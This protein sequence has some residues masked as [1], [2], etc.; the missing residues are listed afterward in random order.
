MRVFMERLRTAAELIRPCMARLLRARP[1][2]GYRAR[3]TRAE[4]RDAGQRLYTAAQEAMGSLSPA[5]RLLV[6]PLVALLPGLGE[7]FPG[8]RVAAADALWQAAQQHGEVLVNR[9]GPLIFITSLPCLVAESNGPIE[10]AVLEPLPVPRPT[11][12]LSGNT[13]RPLSPGLALADGVEIV[14]GGAGWQLR[15]TAVVNGEPCEE[16][17][18]LAAGDRIALPAG[19][20][21][22]IEVEA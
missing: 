21:L 6:D 18:L 11:H 12:L 14:D 3:V 17:Q 9:Q 4:M 19:E 7:Q 22:F 8:L 1:R 15:G 2:N 13:A 10:P 20:A 5:D 16:G